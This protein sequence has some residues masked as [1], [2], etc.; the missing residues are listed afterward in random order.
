M[1]NLVIAEPAAHD[2]GGIVDYIALDNPIAAEGVYRE[3]MKAAQKLPQFPGI[4]RPGRHPE[5]RELVVPGLPYLIVYEVGPETVTILAV[6]H[7]ARD[8][9]RVMRDRMMPS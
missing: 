6:F 9:A 4:G 3:I 2:L 7:T 5:T 1:K 8:L